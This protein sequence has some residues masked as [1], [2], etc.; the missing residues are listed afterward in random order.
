MFKIKIFDDISFRLEIDTERRV[1]NPNIA[2][3]SILGNTMQEGESVV[4]RGTR[5]D[6]KTKGIMLLKG[7]KIVQSGISL[8]SSATN[9]QRRATLYGMSYFVTL[10]LSL[11]VFFF[12]L[13]VACT[14]YMLIEDS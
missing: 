13:L 11:L 9:V 6:K 14:S 8:S 1:A 3:V 2:H 5:L 4:Q 12:Q 10:T 7:E